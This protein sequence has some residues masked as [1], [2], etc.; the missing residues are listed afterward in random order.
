MEEKHR[1]QSALK[2]CPDH[3][4]TL[5]LIVDT[6]NIIERML[7]EA[8]AQALSISAEKA[9]AIFYSLRGSRAQLEIAKCVLERF[10]EPESLRAQYLAQT[11]WAERLFRQRNAM[12][13]NIWDAQ[14]DKAA[15]RDFSKPLDSQARRRPI[16]INEL[17]KL[18]AELEE[19]L[20]GIIEI[21]I[22]AGAWEP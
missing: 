15:I 6:C 22:F 16:P 14:G 5:G 17:E 8:F 3:A 2:N 12:V 4:R 10:A 1:F 13:H 21:S 7:C 19:C 20:N 18:L 9:E 11:E